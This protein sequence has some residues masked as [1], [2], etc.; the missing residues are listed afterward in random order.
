[1]IKESEVEEIKKL[2]KSWKAKKLDPY[3]CLALIHDI[4]FP[5]TKEEILKQAERIKRCR[6]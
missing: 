1:M 2:I 4:L 3:L 5:L 6:S